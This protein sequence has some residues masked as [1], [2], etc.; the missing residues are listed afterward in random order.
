MPLPTVQL[1]YRPE[2]QDCSGKALGQALNKPVVGVPTLTLAYN[3]TGK[4]LSADHGCQ[5]EQV[6][7]SIYRSEQCT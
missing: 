7:T 6:Y 5:E 4:G 2:D 1:F 3:L